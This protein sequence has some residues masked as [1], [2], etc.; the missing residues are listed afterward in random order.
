MEWAVD[1]KNSEN[2]IV[3]IRTF[4]GSICMENIISSWEYIIRE[5]VLLPDHVGVVSDYRHTEFQIKKEDVEKLH[6]YFEENKSIFKTLR[7]AQIVDTPK[8]VFPMLFEK[9]HP[10][11]KSQAFSTMKAALIWMGA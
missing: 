11:F 2:P 7:V 9:N 1:Y 3:L 8:I 4:N 10:G 6:A 5:E